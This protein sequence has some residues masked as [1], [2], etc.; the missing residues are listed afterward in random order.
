MSNAHDNYSP[1]QAKEDAHAAAYMVYTGLLDDTAVSPGRA[2]DSANAWEDYALE[3]QNTPPV[4][5]ALCLLCSCGVCTE[6]GIM[7]P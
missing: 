3:D 2:F 5:P 4:Y 1:A 7:T 6:H